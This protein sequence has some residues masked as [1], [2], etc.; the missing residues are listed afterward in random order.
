MSV[1]KTA[2]NRRDFLKSTSLALGAAAASDLAL[3]R[4][5]HA[6]GSD[7]LRIG[8]V[9]CGGR[10]AGAAVNAL[11]ADPNTRLAAMADIFP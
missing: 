2:A 1:S 3:G 9:G 7:L 8:L 4:S 11:N 5:V 6:A 10:G